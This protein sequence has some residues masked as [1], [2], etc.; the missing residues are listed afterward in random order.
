MS[1]IAFTLA[2]CIRANSYDEIPHL[3]FRGFS[4]DRIKQGSN[5][6]DSVIMTL[7]FTDGDGNFGSA[8]NSAEPNIFLKDLRTNQ[9]FREYKAPIV[10]EEGANNGISGTINVK[11]YTTCCIYEPATGIPPCEPT[12]IFPENVLPL[13]V[14]ISDR[15]GNISNI[16]RTT[17]LI[18]QCN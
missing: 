2:G 7:F 17:D 18:L 6:Q 13:E 8:A 9:I 12:D 3:E 15:A 16:V 5:Q 14:Y 10:P 1:L 11:I 4:K